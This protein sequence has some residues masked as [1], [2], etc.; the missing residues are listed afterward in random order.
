MKETFEKFFRSSGITVTEGKRPGLS[1]R[2]DA[3][4]EPLRRKGCE[5]TDCL[6]CAKGKPGMCETNSAVYRIKCEG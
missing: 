1:L 2:S 6:C 4:S 5:R 3:K